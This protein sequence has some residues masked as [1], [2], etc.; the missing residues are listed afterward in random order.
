MRKRPD[1]DDQEPEET[2]AEAQAEMY[3][4][5][6]KLLDTAADCLRESM[7]VIKEERKKQIR[8]S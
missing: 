8:R 4:S 6:S 5:L 2:V 7:L 3:R 1:Q